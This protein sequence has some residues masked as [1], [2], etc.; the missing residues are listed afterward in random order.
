M[1]RSHPA[2]HFD[3]VFGSFFSR[4]EE[5]DGQWSY[6][7]DVCPRPS[8]QTDS[9]LSSGVILLQL[10]FPFAATTF[11]FVFWHMLHIETKNLSRL[12][13]VHIF[14]LFLNSLLCFYKSLCDAL[15]INIV[16]SSGY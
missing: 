11:P 10:L 16:E 6:L 14:C 5:E 7:S 1:S 8:D 9:A 13:L 15:D 2:G 3:C 12:Q 4:N